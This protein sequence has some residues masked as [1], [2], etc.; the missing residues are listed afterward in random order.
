M[1]SDLPNVPSFCDSALFSELSFT[2]ILHLILFK[3][4]S[5]DLYDVCYQLIDIFLPHL[6]P[7]CMFCA[8]HTFFSTQSQICDQIMS[9]HEDVVRSFVHC[10]A[11][12]SYNERNRI[13]N[14]FSSNVKNLYFRDVFV[15]KVF[16]SFLLFILLFT[17][18]LQYF[19][20]IFS[21]LMIVFLHMLLPC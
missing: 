20:D 11:L 19:R 1:N 13:V 16:F 21:S 17:Y 10:F 12:I 18:E 4:Q 6:E 7:R 2:D 8:L 14:F 15:I 5:T 9:Y 3:C